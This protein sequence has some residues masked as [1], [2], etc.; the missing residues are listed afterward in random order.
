MEVIYTKEDFHLEVE[1]KK[2]EKKSPIIIIWPAKD[3]LM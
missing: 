2:L 3:K 1:A